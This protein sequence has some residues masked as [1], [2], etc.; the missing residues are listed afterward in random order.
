MAHPLDPHP[1]SSRDSITSS[2]VPTSTTDDDE[3]FEDFFSKS[4]PFIPGNNRPL[5]SPTPDNI[6]RS[7]SPFGRR[8]KK[9]INGIQTKGFARSGTYIYTYNLIFISNT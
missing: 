6:I 5:S 7:A 9:P 4:P 8:Y 3:E 1:T 2:P